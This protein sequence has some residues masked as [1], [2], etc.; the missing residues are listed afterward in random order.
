MP[1]ITCRRNTSRIAARA[2]SG[3]EHADP[4]QH[5]RRDGD[6]YGRRRSST[7]TA[8]GARLDV[9]GDD[10]R[11]AAA[12]RSPSRRGV[13]Q[14]HLGVPAV[15][16]ADE[17]HDVGPGGAQRADPA[18]SSGPACTC[19]TRPPADS[20]TRRPASAVTSRS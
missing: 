16:A 14:Q 11:R 1:P 6:A 17:Q 8:L 4:R 5:V 20:P 19:T 10:D 2:P 12:G 13:V 18:A 7:A 3:L 9:A 15:G